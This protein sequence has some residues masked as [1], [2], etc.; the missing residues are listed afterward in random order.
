MHITKETT[1]PSTVTSFTPAQITPTYSMLPTPIP[2]NYHRYQ[3]HRQ[4][5]YH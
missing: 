4:T 1:A 2:P 5:Y 3:F